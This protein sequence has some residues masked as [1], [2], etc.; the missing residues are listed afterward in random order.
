[1][2]D[3][4]DVHG[5]IGPVAFGELAGAVERIDDPHPTGGEPAPVVLAL[6]GQDRVVGL[7]AAQ[8]VDEELVGEAV[9]LVAELLGRQS[10]GTG[11]GPQ[12]LEQPAGLAG[13]EVGGGVIGRRRDGHWG[14]RPPGEVDE[15]VAALDGLRNVEKRGPIPTSG[16]GRQVQ[17]EDGAAA[18]LRGVDVVV[19]AVGNVRIRACSH[20]DV[21]DHCPAI[22]HPEMVVVGPM[23]VGPEAVTRLHRQHPG[24][25]TLRSPQHP[26][27]HPGDRPE[28]LDGQGLDGLG[29]EHERL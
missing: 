24:R 21:Q 17:V 15:Q 3:Q 11:P 10:G 9:T 6:L 28:R 29:G 25:R 16:A 13:E 2:L 19:D 23:A 1:M 27:V 18:R 22:E 7:E 26:V 5:P 14:S 4:G 20:L 8:L 12:R